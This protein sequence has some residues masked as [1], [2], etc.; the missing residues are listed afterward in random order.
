MITYHSAV[1]NSTDIGLYLESSSRQYLVTGSNFT[2]SKRPL[3]VNA[4]RNAVT[5]A[6][7]KFYGNSCSS[8]SCRSIEAIIYNSYI[9]FKGNVLEG[10]TANQIL[11]IYKGSS[12]SSTPPSDIIITGNIFRSNRVPPS[13]SGGNAVLAMRGNNVHS[14]WNIN[15]N[16][17][18]NLNSMYEMSSAGLSVSDLST[19]TINATRNFFPFAD[20]LNKSL[21]D[22]RL[23]DDDEGLHPEILFEP[24]LTVNSTIYCP[25]DCTDRGVCVYPGLCICKDGWSG[26][27]C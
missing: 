5:V 9:M 7:N 8:P 12:G 11:S 13:T 16:E 25:L 21:I 20:D 17:F 27:A 6:L 19:V 26:I 2:L 15:Q 23:Y 10:N 18:N 1:S 22:N 24:Y 14:F 4:D 3:Y